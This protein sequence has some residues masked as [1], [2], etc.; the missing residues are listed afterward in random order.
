LIFP[1][2]ATRYLNSQTTGPRA[3]SYIHLRSASV[4]RSG[5]CGSRRH[6]EAAITHWT[7]WKTKR[8]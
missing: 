1:D 6:V 3:V 5:G 4:K 2:H 8:L 7:I